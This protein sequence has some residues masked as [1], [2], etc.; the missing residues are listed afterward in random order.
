MPR[1][2]TVKTFQGLMASN[3]LSKETEGDR[4]SIFI[5]AMAFKYKVSQKSMLYRLKDL[6]LISIL[7]T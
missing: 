7:S 5:E 3:V 2:I 4:I 1:N 6:K